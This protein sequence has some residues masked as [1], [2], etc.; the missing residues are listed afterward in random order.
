MAVTL[1]REREKIFFLTL[2]F[3]EEKKV[4]TAI[5]LEGGGVKALMVQPLKNNFF[6]AASLL[7]NECKWVQLHLENSITKFKM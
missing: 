6:F 4:P 3:E 7:Q 5:K 1:R 2:N